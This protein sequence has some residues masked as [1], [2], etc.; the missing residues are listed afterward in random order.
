MRPWTHIQKMPTPY[1][2]DSASSFLF[3]CHAEFSVDSLRLGLGMSTVTYE[4]IREPVRE[5]TF[6][7]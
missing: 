5:P 7:P 3:L 6:E 2:G 1:V 4:P